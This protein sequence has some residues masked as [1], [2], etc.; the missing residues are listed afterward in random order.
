MGVRER[1][2]ARGLQDISNTRE[3]FT[4]TRLQHDQLCAGTYRGLFTT[5][6]SEYSTVVEGRTDVPRFW[7]KCVAR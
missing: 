4:K 1:W 5:T 7:D 3:K 2:R 6:V